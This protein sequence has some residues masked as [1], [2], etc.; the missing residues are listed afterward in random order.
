ME[1]NAPE[2]RRFCISLDWRAEIPFALMPVKVALLVGA[3][4]WAAWWM[5]MNIGIHSGL[6]VLAAIA[7][8]GARHVMISGER[9]GQYLRRL[10]GGAIVVSGEGLRVL[11]A[12]GEWRTFPWR[13]IVELRVVTL[14]GLLSETPAS[15][16]ANGLTISIPV[17]VDDREE[18]LRLIRERGRLMRVREGWWSTVYRR[19]VGGER[20]E[21]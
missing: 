9:I 1:E 4:L 21:A 6:F 18:L 17:Y 2:Q 13:E 15:V 12:Q 16:D 20:R 3:P 11:P 5:A 10:R 14:G 7:F 8:M 19:H